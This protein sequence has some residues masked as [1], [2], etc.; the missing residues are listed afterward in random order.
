MDCGARMIFA[1]SPPNSQPD[2]RCGAIWASASAVF[3]VRSAG[4]R[5]RSWGNL[6]ALGMALALCLGLARHAAASSRD[7][8]VERLAQQA[9]HAIDKG[10]YDGATTLYMGAWRQNPSLVVLVFNAARAQHLA[11]H[12]DRAEALYRQFLAVAPPADPLFSLA[13]AY[14]GD[15][16][17]AQADFVASDAAGL[18]QSGRADESAAAWRV[19]F[20]LAPS[21]PVY[22]LAAARAARLGKSPDDAVADYQRYIQAVPAGPERQAAEQELL[23]YRTGKLVRLAD[24]LLAAARQ[25]GDLPDD[26]MPPCREREERCQCQRTWTADLVGHIGR[27]V[28]N[29]QFVAEQFAKGNTITAD[30]AAIALGHDVTAAAALVGHLGECPLVGAGPTVRQTFT[31]PELPE[32]WQAELEVV[33]NPY[34]VPMMFDLECQDPMTQMPTAFDYRRFARIKVRLPVVVD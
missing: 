25:I 22:L 23:A 31:D 11:G 7:Q 21:R 16:Q 5:I 32:Q 19:A 26:Y 27:A 14:L 28:V 18:A 2:A 29:L 13:T 15:V 4:M 24:A 10:D 9:K 17:L 20:R 6:A 30:R 1:I 3:A 12:F 33:E 34:V 8:T